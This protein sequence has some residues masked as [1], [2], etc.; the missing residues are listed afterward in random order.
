[1]ITFTTGNLLDAPVDALVNTVNEVGVMGKGIALMFK[2]AFPDNTRAYQT[3]C[4]A[5]EVQVGRMFVT[6]NPTLQGPRWIINFPTKKHWR[7]PTRREWVE[8][9]LQD[10][11]RVIRDKGIRSVAVP[12][13]G[14]G[15]GGL[16]WPDVRP[17]IEAALGSLTDVEVMVFEPTAVYQNVRKSTGVETLTPA[18]ALIAD[19]VRRYDVLGIDCTNLEVH[20]LAWFLSRQIQATGLADPLQLRFVAN[21]YGPYADQLRHLLNSLDGSYLHCAKR[22]G[23]ATP[24]DRIWFETAKK[25]KVE[26]FLRQDA[27]PYLE[28]LEQA[29]TLIDGFESPLGLELLATVDWLLH[30]ERCQPD[31]PAIR[32]GLHQWRGGGRDAAARKENLFGDRLL[33]LALDRLREH[34]PPTVAVVVEAS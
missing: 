27:A 19:L 28:A 11:V 8:E 9:G 7:H 34:Q 2:E 33:Q 14:C 21:R 31:L 3:A 1:M 24:F 17:L 29:T 32:Q 16:K 23:D 15:Q 13:L 5:G 26:Q 4:K 6:A 25:E 22:L 18:R 12:P 10:L 20:K 30:E